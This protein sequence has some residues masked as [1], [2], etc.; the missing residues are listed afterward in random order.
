MGHT[1]QV[2]LNSLRGRFPASFQLPGFSFHGGE[3][4]RI[5]S[6]PIIG[7]VLQDVTA[8]FIF[9]VG[10]FMQ[11]DLWNRFSFPGRTLLSLVEKS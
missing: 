4:Y 10:G 8:A 9:D 11:T 7:P 2:F 5:D 1:P 6:V 3:G